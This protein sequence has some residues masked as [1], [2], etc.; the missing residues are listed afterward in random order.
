MCIKFG[1]N[2]IRVKDE[3][4][5]RDEEQEKIKWAVMINGQLG[6]RRWRGL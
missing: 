6:L 3:I 5:Y 2:K 1:D 4:N